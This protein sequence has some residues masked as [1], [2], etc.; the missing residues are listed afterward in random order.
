MHH[1]NQASANLSF[2][3]ASA[4]NPVT[5][6]PDTGANQHVTPGIAGMTHADPYLGND[7]LYVGD[8]K[9]LIISNTAHKILHTPK[10]TFT[11]S[12]ILHVP[13]IK[14]RLLSVQQ[15]CRDNCVF[16]EFHSSFFYVKDLITKAVLLSGQSKD[17]LY[18][19]TESSTT[20]LPQAFLSTSAD[21]WHRRLGHPSSRVLS[22]LAS[23]KKVVCTSRP[24]NFHCQA[25]PLG[26]SSRLSLGLTGHQTSAP[27]DL[28]FSDV[29]GPAP[30][31]SSDGF[32]YFVIFVDAHTKFI[33]FYP[34]VLKS[35]V[36]NVFHQFQVFVERQFSRKIKSV[37]TDWGG[38]YR[39]LNSFFKTIGIHHRLICPH[40]HE[41]NGTVECRHR[42]IVEAGLTLLG[43]CK[44]PLKFWTYAF[45][46]SVYLINRMPTPVLCNKSPFECLLHQPP[47]YDFLRTF[48]CLCFPFLRPYN[49]HK[50]DY[51]S[52]PC[53]FLGYSSSHL[54]Y[55]CLDLLSKRLY[56]SRHVRFNEHVFSFLESAHLP[57]P[58]SHTHPPTIVTHL[59]SLTIFPSTTPL[60][61]PPTSS[62]PVVL[63]SPSTSIY[64]DHC[65]GTGSP[66]P[67]LS[68]FASPPAVVSPA[69]SSSTFSPSKSS[70]MSSPGL[71]LC[72]DL[73]SY[74]LPQQPSPVQTPAPPAQRQHHMV[75]RPRHNRT[76]NIT[77]VAAFSSQPP[78]SRVMSPSTP[79]PLTFKEVDQFMC[80]HTA[81]KS[82]IAALHANGTWSLVPFDPSMNVVGCRWVYKI[83][84]RADGA[85]D[86][87]KARLVARG[88]TQQEGIDYSKTFS[89][90]VKPTTIRLVLTIVVSKGWQIRQLDVHN[91]FLNGS[92]REVLYMAQPTSFVNSALPNHVCLLHRSLYGLN[93]PL[94]LG[95]PV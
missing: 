10:R 64:V 78:A 71:D 14:K 91:A 77:S 80:W 85:I 47:N 55:H 38:E 56:I 39:K 52:T 22:L 17:G 93:K 43:L 74:T 76:A 15:F 5:W 19:L 68:M 95:T 66:T 9:G 18:I 84:R 32:C 20:C 44:T 58:T 92:L 51:R 65:A 24:L 79:E 57:P 28:V 69:W 87:Y 41:Q 63:L 37:Q 50:L 75:L 83:K 25:C 23:N 54:G 46:T 33:W 27:L 12:N 81:M 49:A 35:D 62:N 67:A 36:F 34:L 42:H 16:F 89:P 82:E 4:E 13:K 45:E 11:L 26:K 53:V 60:D 30:M 90:V 61:P 86:R 29:W 7:Q 3:D 88:F 59:P 70:T 94:G 48:G 40:T 31:L 8:G 1:G 73:S 2:R 72:V 6:F 21:V